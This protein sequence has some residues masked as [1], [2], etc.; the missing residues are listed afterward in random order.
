LNAAGSG[1]G[2]ELVAVHTGPINPFITF[3]LGTVYVEYRQ[4][5]RVQ[6]DTI[7]DSGLA[8]VGTDRDRAAI[9]VHVVRPNPTG[10]TPV[11]WYAGRIILPT[12]DLDLTVDTPTGQITVSIDRINASR[13]KPSSVGI[14]I[15]RQSRREVVITEAH[16]DK[17][18]VVASEQ[19]PHPQLPAYLG[20]ATWEKREVTR[21][22]HY[23]A[24]FSGLGGSG[25]FDG[26]V[27]TAWQW[28]VAGQR[29]D[30]QFSRLTVTV[31]GTAAQV[32]INYRID[33]KLAGLMLSNRP[34]DGSYTL[35]VS[36]MATANGERDLVEMG[37]NFV[38][39]GTEEGWGDDYYRALWWRNY[40]LIPIIIGDPPTW[41]VKEARDLA[42]A[43]LA[44]LAV[45]NPALARS[46]AA[47]FPGVALAEAVI[48][49]TAARGRRRPIGPRAARTQKPK[50]SKKSKK[51]IR[52]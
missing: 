48:S 11:C 43:Q 23:N 51:S 5:S 16:E 12:V 36:F 52:V 22:A 15:R 38:A 37:P 30:P 9:V 18:V 2:V 49:P 41:M 40:V 27:N 3:K 47:S 10:N 31:P 42:E 35:P 29:L 20:T 39:P 19:R 46:I 21:N 24:T 25:V 45:I 50:K 1:T 44:E 26:S 32:E 34:Q 8:D 7:W 28:L 33:R 13:D 14:S 17:T 6:D 4:P